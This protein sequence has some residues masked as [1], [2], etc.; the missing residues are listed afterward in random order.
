MKIII[1]PSNLYHNQWMLYKDARRLNQQ[2]YVRGKNGDIVHY[3]SRSGARGVRS[4]I[5]SDVRP[6][7]YSMQLRR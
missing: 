2:D 1:V 6:E 7:G 4:M 5:L 3:K